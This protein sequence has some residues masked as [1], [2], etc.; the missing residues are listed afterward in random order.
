LPAGV[1][2]RK[3]VAQIVAAALPGSGRLLRYHL[4]LDS[5]GRTQL[6]LEG[7]QVSTF[8][9]FDEELLA[10]LNAIDALLAAPRDFAWLL[11]AMGGLALEHVDTIAVARLEK[12]GGWAG[13]LPCPALRAPGRG[14]SLLASEFERNRKGEIE[15]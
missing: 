11:D 10:A 7:R 14:R 5:E 2:L 3:E 9:Y 6:L 15:A 13:S 1:F 4:S 8:R 12:A